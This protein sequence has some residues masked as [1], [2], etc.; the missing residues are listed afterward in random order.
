MRFNLVESGFTTLKVYTILGTEIAT[1][2]NGPLNAGAHTIVF[3]SSGLPSGVYVYRL[4]SG[5]YL[6]TKK[7][8]L[9]K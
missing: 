5:K 8:I 1:L 6:E 3:R 9:L 4:I 2:V 7:M